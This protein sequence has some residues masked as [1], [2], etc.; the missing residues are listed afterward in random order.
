M[1]EFDLGGITSERLANLNSEQRSIVEK[2]LEKDK[3]RSKLVAMIDVGDEETFERVFNALRD[4]YS[5]YCEHRRCVWTNCIACS[6]I[7]M[8]LYPELYDKNGAR[9]E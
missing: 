3:E 9:H 6:E 4:M 7:E 2:R 1:D 8:L 5:D